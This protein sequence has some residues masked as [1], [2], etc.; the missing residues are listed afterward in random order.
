MKESLTPTSP[1]L[2]SS[3]SLP[4]P[5]SPDTKYVYRRYDEFSSTLQSQLYSLPP[6]SECR[7]LLSKGIDKTPQLSPHTVVLQQKKDEG[8]GGA[9]VDD[10][11]TKDDTN[12]RMTII[13]PKGSTYNVK[14][15]YILPITQENQLIIVSPET[16]DY[17]RLCIVQTPKDHSFI[18]IGCAFAFT[19]GNVDCSKRL[20][21]DKSPSSLE[22]AKKNFPT[23]DLEELDVLVESKEGLMNILERYEMNDCGKLIVAIDIN[24]NRELEA[25]V[26]CLQ[27][28][29]D[30]WRPRLVI[31]KSRSLFKLMND[32]GT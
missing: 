1:A 9:R 2:S 12:D 7:L 19:V 5:S 29:L 21:I 11:E 32:Q 18:E 6:N 28:I 8:K 20:G 16:T 10:C 30:V 22:L 14:K 25:V 13:Y 26:E 23:L 3:P 15:K 4:Q 17:R 31:V 24:G 27:R